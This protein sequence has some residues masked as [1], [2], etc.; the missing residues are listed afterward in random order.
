MQAIYNAC[1]EKDRQPLVKWL[2]ASRL[3]GE[4][5]YSE[6]DSRLVRWARSAK[7]WNSDRVPDSWTFFAHLEEALEKTDSDEC[8]RIAVLHGDVDILAWALHMLSAEVIKNAALWMLGKPDVYFANNYHGKEY[9]NFR[10][11]AAEMLCWSVLG[12]D[13]T[14]DKNICRLGMLTGYEQL[15]TTLEYRGFAVCN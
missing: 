11:D 9:E 5:S 13:S 6:F 1:L 3:V 10:L 12:T 4:S 2:Y 15:T 7:L 14:K 8:I